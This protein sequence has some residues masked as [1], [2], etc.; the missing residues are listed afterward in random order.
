MNQPKI[1]NLQRGGVRRRGGFS[2][3]EL[4]VVVG[5]IISL[6]SLVLAV[7]TLL[8]QANESRQLEAAFANLNTAVQEY[9]NRRSA[10]R[11]PIRIEASRAFEAPMTSRT[12]S[13]SESTASRASTDSTGLEKPATADRIPTVTGGRSRSFVSSS[14][15]REP[16]PLKKWSRSSIRRCSFRSS[17]PT[18]SRFPT[19][20]L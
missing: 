20:R 2:L 4:V 5:V 11:S 12:T 10:V 13:T 1:H 3:I 16:S 8:I 15:W 14:F 19:I 6:I 18:V 9:T 17:W 7:S